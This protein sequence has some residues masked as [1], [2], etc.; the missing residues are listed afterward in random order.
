PTFPRPAA[1]AACLRALAELDSPRDRYEAIVVVDGGVPPA[2]AIAHAQGLL[3]VSMIEQPNAGPAA[4]RNTG[5]MQARG[6]LLAFTDDDCL[7]DRGWLRA[8][9]ERG[10]EQDVLAGGRIVNGAPD[11]LYAEASQLVLDF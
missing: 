4:A 7:P 2:E 10:I 11:N 9:A 1:L 8:F 6:D 3:D 5:A